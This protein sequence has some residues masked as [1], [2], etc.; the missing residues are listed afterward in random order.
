MKQ[1]KT[2]LLALN[3]TPE[4]KNRILEYSERT[5]QPMARAMRDLLDTGLVFE[6][7]SERKAKEARQ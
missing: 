3:V 7:V 1:N 5:R 4:F 6:A 2:E